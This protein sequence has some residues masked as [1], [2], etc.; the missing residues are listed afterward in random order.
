MGF[1]LV[2]FSRL[3]HSGERDSDEPFV[4]ANQAQQVIF[5]QD[6]IERDWFVPRQI[7]PRD[8]YDMGEKNLQTEPFINLE[9]SLDLEKDNP[10]WVRNDVDGMVVDMDQHFNLPT[11]EYEAN[12][13]EQGTFEITTLHLFLNYF[14]QFGITQAVY[15]NYF[16]LFQ[17][18][19]F[20]I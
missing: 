18:N 15:L 7:K 2:N 3:I 11:N 4:F 10:D 16:C 12:D 1:T 8:I 13:F 6:P 14:L 5:V 9:D 19:Y 20:I 17:Y